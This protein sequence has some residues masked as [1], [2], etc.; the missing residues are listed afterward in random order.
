M[1][2]ECVTA[3][4]EMLVGQKSHSVWTMGE[5]GSSGTGSGSWGKVDFSLTHY[6]RVPMISMNYP[7]RFE[8]GLL[9]RGRG[10]TFA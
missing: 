5:T 2:F 1:Q 9:S 4:I 10:E 3:R 8:S 6:M 7:T